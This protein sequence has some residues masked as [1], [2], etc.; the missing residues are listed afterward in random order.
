MTSPAA[1]PISPVP[2][3]TSAILTAEEYAVI[4]AKFQ[5]AGL[6]PLAIRQFLALVNTEAEKAAVVAGRQVAMAIADTFLNTIQNVHDQTADRIL[7]NLSLRNGGR[8][9]TAVH[10]ECFN[11][12]LNERYGANA[13]PTIALPTQ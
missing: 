9:R 5:Q 7:H 10:Q 4:G 6:D 8:V 2:T 1:R 11:A 3:Q 13:R 12:V